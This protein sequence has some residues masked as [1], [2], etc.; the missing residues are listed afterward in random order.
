MDTTVEEA[1]HRYHKAAGNKHSNGRNV[2]Q[3]MIS[4]VEMFSR[5][6]LMCK[7][8]QFASHKSNRLISPPEIPHHSLDLENKPLVR[9]REVARW[10]EQEPNLTN[11]IRKLLELRGYTH[12]KLHFYRSKGNDLVESY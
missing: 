2:E 1:W 9:E 12:L 11:R 10:K 7:Q 4:K 5:V 8:H 6:S 3:R